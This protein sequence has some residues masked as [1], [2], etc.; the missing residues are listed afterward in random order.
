V[1][2]SSA[3]KDPATCT[4]SDAGSLPCLNSN[5]SI[6]ITAD[7]SK[8]ALPK[9]ST[10]HRK[11]AFILKES[12][13]QLAGMY[14]L[15]YLGF[16]T[17]TFSKHITNPKKASKLLNSLLSNVIKPRYGDYV[18]V[19]ER[20]KSGRIHYHLL[21]SL[22]V[23]IRTGFDFDGIAN[24]DYRS[25]SPALRSE[26]AF[27]RKTAPLYGFGRTELLPIKSTTQAIAK[28]V[29]KYIAKHIESR[30]ID[31]KGARLVRYSIG[32]RAGTTRFSFNSPGSAEWR[33]KLAI[34][35]E[36]VQLRHP[37]TIVNKLEDLTR[38]LGPRWA[39][40]HRDYILGLP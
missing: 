32:A 31:D 26:W 38:V 30:H 27:L 11:T 39:H 6:Q 15:E 3:Q 34:F 33:R 9:L 25:A 16:L 17:L 24:N 1:Q 19:M 14:G 29:G 8:S 35:S 12:V 13:Q 2:Y 7:Q 37:E 40:T 4:N 36:I 18:G 22:P 23:D 28:Y 10:Q 21:V 20:Q 5:I